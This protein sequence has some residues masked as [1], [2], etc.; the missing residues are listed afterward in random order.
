MDAEFTPQVSATCK[1]GHMNIKVAFNS[2]FYG[3]VH[4]RDHRSS[5]CMTHGDGS[6]L[7]SLDINLL[8]VNGAPDYCGLLLNNVSGIYNHLF[9]RTHIT[10]LLILDSSFSF[11]RT[12]LHEYMR[13]SSSFLF[14]AGCKINNLVR[15]INDEFRL[16]LLYKFY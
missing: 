4:A 7:V 1:A 2:S 11:S 14:T 9:L 13:R 10:N 15:R 8:A 6:K 5:A 12:F 3:A 16:Q